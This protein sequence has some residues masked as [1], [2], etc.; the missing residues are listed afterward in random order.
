M[1]TEW[2]MVADHAEILNNKAYIMSGGW[3]QIIVNQALPIQHPMAIVA[4][5]TIPW[6][7]TNEVHDIFL[8]IIDQDGQAIVQVQG[9]LEVGRP[10]GISPGQSQ[11]QHFAL[12]MAL[13]IDK[14]GPYVVKARAG[15][16]EKSIRFTVAAGPGMP[17]P[18]MSA[19]GPQ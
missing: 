5:F 7:Q 9:Q 1:E 3:D 18:D 15:G 17:R 12:N 10:P 6:N 19:F 14:L 11:R 2:L 8:E 13:G 4:A 16:K